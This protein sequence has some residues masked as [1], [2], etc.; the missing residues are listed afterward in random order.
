M[1]NSDEKRKMKKLEEQVETYHIIIQKI[2]A[3]FDMKGEI[4]RDLAGLKRNKM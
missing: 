3:Y 2:R 4:M 1:L